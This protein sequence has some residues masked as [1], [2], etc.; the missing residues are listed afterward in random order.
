MRC[1]RA[2]RC[3]FNRGYSDFTV[4]VRNVSATG[5]KLSGDEL[6]RLP[7]EFELQIA[8]TAGAVIDAAGPQDVEPAGFDRRR[9]PRAGAPGAEGRGRAVGRGD[10]LACVNSPLAMMGFALR[11]NRAQANAFSITRRSRAAKA[12]ASLKASPSASRAS[13]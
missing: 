6:F 7:D 3:V 4:M 13:S 8:N 5:A 2:A 9:I 11:A 12:G 1:L 10:A